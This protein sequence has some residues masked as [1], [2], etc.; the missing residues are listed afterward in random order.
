MST[1][2]GGMTTSEFRKHLGLRSCLRFPTN[3]C[4]ALIL[5][6]NELPND[7][8]RRDHGPDVKN[9]VKLST[10]QTIDLIPKTQ[11]KDITDGKVY[12]KGLT[13]R[14][15]FQLLLLNLNQLVKLECAFALSKI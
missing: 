1:S 7:F 6:S 9:Q 8:D 5:P 4:K 14:G 15:I 12:F 11:P 10:G 13:G 2:H 3:V